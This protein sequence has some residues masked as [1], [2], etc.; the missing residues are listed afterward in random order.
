[1]NEIR[2]TGCPAVQLLKR[3]VHLVLDHNTNELQKEDKTHQHHA[4]D[5]EDG[6]RAPLRL[7]GRECMVN[8][9]KASAHETN[10]ADQRNG[11]CDEGHHNVGDA[12]RLGNSGD[13]STAQTDGHGSEHQCNNEETTH[14]LALPLAIT[15]EVRLAL[16]IAV[17]YNIVVTR[18]IDIKVLGT[19]V[20]LFGVAVLNGNPG[21]IL[22]HTGLGRVADNANKEESEGD[23]GEASGDSVN[24]THFVGIGLKGMD[25]L[26]TSSMTASR[27]ILKFPVSVLYAFLNYHL[28][29]ITYFNLVSPRVHRRYL[30][31]IF[32]GKKR[33][34]H[35]KN[36][37]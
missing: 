36:N 6:T 22:K 31:Q 26:L 19:K 35:F 37:R 30:T 15:T 14:D 18:S 16:I 3:F 32:R 34:G 23:H 28:E 24:S 4:D 21:D 8:L 33:N 29:I 12:Q 9:G 1:M 13:R 20:V 10:N 27:W 17:K 7:L 2:V 5:G 11:E 25:S